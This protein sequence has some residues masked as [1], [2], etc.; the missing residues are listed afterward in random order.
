MSFS[1]FVRWVCDHCGHAEETGPKK[2]PKSGV[3]YKGEGVVCGGS[4]IGKT[5]RGFWLCGSCSTNFIQY[6]RM[7]DAL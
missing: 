3:L 7:T 1:H 4:E 5:I 6:C 2:N